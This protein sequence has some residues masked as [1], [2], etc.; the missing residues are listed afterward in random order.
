MCLLKT[1]DIRIR[2]PF[3]T[4][5]DGIYYMYGTN[6]LHP[7]KNV[8][9]VYK[10]N[11]L[12]NWSGPTEIFRLAGGTWAKGELWAPEVHLYKGKFYMLL[13]L[14]GNHGM[15][16]TQVF[17]SDTPDG[18]FQP[19]CNG[20]ATPFHRSCIDG[21]LYIEKGIP[22]IIYSAD[23]PDNYDE[24]K[25]CYVGEIWAVEMTEDLT[26]QA[27]EPFRLFR[28]DESPSS[29]V[30]TPVV[31][32]NGK[33]TRYGSDGPFLTTLTNGNIVLTWSP[34][35]ERNYVVAAAISENG[36]RGKWRHLENIYDNNGGHAMFFDDFDGTK[37]MVIHYPER[38]PEERAVVFTVEERDGILQLTE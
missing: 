36:I 34:I 35:P 18:T 6:C 23:W 11:D 30:G 29:Y 28:S 31:R 21:T 32:E 12:E 33:T 4:L 10:S 8:L 17:V 26:K 16:G 19:I 5:H 7:E 2:D 37:K 13:T 27:G 24:K 15:R 1:K 38:Y 9:Y 25:G 3:I 20:P 22:Y 14:L